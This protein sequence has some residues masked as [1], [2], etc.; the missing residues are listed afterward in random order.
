MALAAIR[1][2]SARNSAVLNPADS[3]SEVLGN[4]FTPV[5]AGA[6]CDGAACADRAIAAGN[7]YITMVIGH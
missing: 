5:D 3:V 2:Y 6:E 4:T 7:G 1:C